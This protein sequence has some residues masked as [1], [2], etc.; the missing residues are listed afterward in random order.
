MCGVEML[1]WCLATL[2]KHHLDIY[3]I[4]W[5]YIY[6]HR[7][8]ESYLLSCILWS[9]HEVVLHIIEGFLPASGVCRLAANPLVSLRWFFMGD[10][11]R[12]SMDFR[13][14]WVW[15]IYFFGSG[16]HWDSMNSLS[17]VRA[18]VLQ[19]LQ[20]SNICKKKG[21]VS[22]WVNN[23]WPRSVGFAQAAAN[24]QSFLSANGFLAVN[25]GFFLVS[26]HVEPLGIFQESL[27]KSAWFLGSKT[28]IG[29]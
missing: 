2:H 3:H 5:I 13:A 10:R 12:I 9:S 7:I 17:K 29:S 15:K 8:W 27:P 24:Q 19:M 21:R 1:F 25:F 6:I 22:A 26:Q 18:Q 11:D 16:P 4:M 28:S 14:Q 23:S 20:N